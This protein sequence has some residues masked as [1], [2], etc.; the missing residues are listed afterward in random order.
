AGVA[1]LDRP[2]RRH[3]VDAG[4]RPDAGGRDPALEKPVRHVLALDG[5]PRARERRPGGV[6]EH[7][8]AHLQ[9]HPVLPPPRRPP[10]R[11]RPQPAVGSEAP[12][13]PEAAVEPLIGRV[14]RRL[15]LLELTQALTQGLRA[16]VDRM[17]TRGEQRGEEDEDGESHERFG[18]PYPK[19]LRLTATRPSRVPC[20]HH[21][22]AP[23]RDR[24]GRA[25]DRAV[26]YARIQYHHAG[27]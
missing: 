11:T 8:D 18:I 2:H 27:A 24:R 10:A 13:R 22:D 20:A 23:Y 14:E 21:E 1:A 6:V 17:C 15:A 12:E 25:L 16:Q 7:L 4:D 9:V 3:A 19:S 5:Q 26:A